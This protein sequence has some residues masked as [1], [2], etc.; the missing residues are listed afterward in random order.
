[1]QVEGAGNAFASAKKKH[2]KRHSKKSIDDGYEH[3]AWNDTD[4]VRVVL[5]LK[6]GADAEAAM[7]YLYKNTP[8][9]TNFHVNLTCLVPV[10]G[11]VSVPKRA[12]LRSSDALGVWYAPALVSSAPKGSSS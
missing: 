12:V 10:E 6:A 2:S 8:L 7:A 4:D 5:E 11:G 3:Q 9:S 1:M